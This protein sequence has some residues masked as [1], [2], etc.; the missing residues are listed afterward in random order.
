MHGEDIK[1]STLT[2]AGFFHDEVVGSPNSS[3]FVKRCE[4][5]YKDGAVQV[6]FNNSIDLMNQTNVLINGY[7]VKLSLY[8][9]T[10]EIIK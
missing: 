10:S 4:M 5:V 8:Q 2:S 3:G 1:N 7:N 9:N 6:A